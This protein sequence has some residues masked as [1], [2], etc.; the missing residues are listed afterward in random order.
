MVVPDGSLIVVH[1]VDPREVGDRFART[2]M[3]WPLHITLVPWFTLNPEPEALQA[4]E[5]V[6]KA[7]VQFSVF[8]GEDAMFGPHKRIA[9][10]LIAEPKQCAELHR[11]LVDSLRPLDFVFA[12]DRWVGE[13]Y[14]PHITHHGERRRQPG[15]T[16]DIKDFTLVRLVDQHT[17][18]VVRHFTLGGEQ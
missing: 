1:L 18:E 8:V 4:L 14:R 10:S 6:A 12:S 11:G 7:S 5:S 15:E 13:S 2:R 3:G 9:V 16:R 17:C